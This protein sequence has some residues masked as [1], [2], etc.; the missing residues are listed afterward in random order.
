M[1]RGRLTAVAG[2]ALTLSG[3]SLVQAQKPEGIRDTMQPVQ[4]LRTGGY[5]IVVRDGATVSHQTNT[6]PLNGGDIAQ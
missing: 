5:T 3:P 4:S 2:S 1:P 6:D